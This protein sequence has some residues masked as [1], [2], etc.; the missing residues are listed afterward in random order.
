M[1]AG[2]AQRQEK[3]GQYLTV[4]GPADFFE[5][6]ADFLHDGIAV[7]IV[8]AFRNLLIIND[9]YGSHDKQQPDEYTDEYTDEKQAAVQTEEGISGL[10]SAFHI[11]V[12]DQP[13]IIIGVV[14][15][16]KIHAGAA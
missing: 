9:Q 13:V 6:H 10:G 16:G 5:A 7:F 12:E 15:D 3:D 11:A 4:N 8:I 1:D 2:N 14:R